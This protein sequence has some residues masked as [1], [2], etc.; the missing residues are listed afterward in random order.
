VAGRHIALAAAAIL[1]LGMCV[2]L[3]VEVRSSPASAQ[4]SGGRRAPHNSEAEPANAPEPQR[5]ATPAVA[6]TRPRVVPQQAAGTGKLT[7]PNVT[8]DPVLP[9]GPDPEADGKASYKLEA[10]M[11]EANKAYDRLEFDEARAIAQKVLARFPGNTRMLRIM[12]SAACI[13]ND[14]PEA[15]KHYNLLPGPDREQMKTRCSRYGVTFT[16]PPSTFAPP[17]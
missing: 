4:A 11:A 7:D 3:F 10:A 16:D 5:T 1:V 9:Q 15:Q 12:V 2:Y 17:K 6:Q 13:E 14:G 8:A